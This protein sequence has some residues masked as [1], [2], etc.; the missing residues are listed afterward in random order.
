M[1]KGRKKKAPRLKG[2]SIG[3]HIYVPDFR[4]IY[5]FEVYEA[6]VIDIKDDWLIVKYDLKED[7]PWYQCLEEGN[8][9]WY[10]VTDETTILIG[11]LKEIYSGVRDIK[12]QLSDIW[13]EH[14]DF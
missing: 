4:S 2:I 3:D 13:L 10:P 14:G 1:A 12:E 11:K 5:G 7:G 9:E 6:E 8:A